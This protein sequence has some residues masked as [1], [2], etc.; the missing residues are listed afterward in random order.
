MCR[1][2]RW[3]LVCV[4]WKSAEGDSFPIGLPVTLCS[5]HWAER[6]HLLC[7]GNILIQTLWLLIHPQSSPTPL[8]HTSED[9]NWPS[10]CGELQCTAHSDTFFHWCFTIILA[11]LSLKTWFAIFLPQI[12]K[13]LF[14]ITL[15]HLSK[16]STS[17]WKKKVSCH[18]LNHVSFSQ[19]PEKQDSTGHLSFFFPLSLTSRLHLGACGEKKQ[20][21]K[22]SKEQ[23]LCEKVT[24]DQQTD[25]ESEMEYEEETEW[26][27]WSVKQAGSRC[28]VER[29]C[30]RGGRRLSRRLSAR[31]LHLALFAATPRALEEFSEWTGDSVRV[32]NGQDGRLSCL[33]PF[34]NCCYL[35]RSQLMIFSFDKMV[36]LFFFFLNW[37]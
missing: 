18:A 31:S 12:D 14:I 33:V 30:K 27:R 2:A 37:V 5:I 10:C 7:A 25:S 22:T 36:K 34:I 21:K 9:S 17:G 23:R 32:D 11:Q 19:I 8:L 13:I 15:L 1:C 6:R 26:K 28:E 35:T 4:T 3:T 24:K 16:S 29:G 20:K